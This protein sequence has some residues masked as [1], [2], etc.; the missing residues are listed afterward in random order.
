MVRR[1]AEI[2]DRFLLAELH[3]NSPKNKTS[4]K[5]I[6]TALSKLTSGSNAYAAA[7]S[8]A[9][10]RI[11]TQPEEHKNLAKKTIAILVTERRP[12]SV[13]ELCHA[14]S[15]DTE[16]EQVDDEEDIRDIED[17]L[18][19]CAGLV[20]TDPGSNMVRL[21]HM[22]TQDYFHQQRAEF[23]PYAKHIVGKI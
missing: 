5:E 10:H 17:I 15:V 6:R 18:S 19:T 21:V 4:V 23:F 16:I 9:W 20:T 3:L 11:N 8:E 22:S 1:I 2:E 12:L 13:E 7:Y 14:L